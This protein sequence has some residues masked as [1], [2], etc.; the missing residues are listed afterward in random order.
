LKLKGLL[1]TVAGVEKVIARVDSD[2][3]TGLWQG[4]AN[5]RVPLSRPPRGFRRTGHGWRQLLAAPRRTRRWRRKAPQHL[6]D[7]L[8]LG[9]SLAN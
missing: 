3:R 1:Q 8:T 6:V 5:I 7:S 2:K 4:D 9:F